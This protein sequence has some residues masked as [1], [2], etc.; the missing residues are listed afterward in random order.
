MLSNKPDHIAIWTE[1]GLATKQV[2]EILFTPVDS[3]K[4][5]IAVQSDSHLTYLVLRWNH[6]W[7]DEIRVLGDH[8]ERGYG[9]LEW[10]GI[11]PERCIPWYAL[12]HHV[13][14]R[15][16]EGFG[17]ETG[18]N[19][20]ASWRIDNSGISLVLD[21]RNG[22]MGVQ[23]GN[24]SLHAATLLSISSHDN[25]SA[26]A[27]AHRF[28]RSLCQ[29]PRLSKHPVYGGNDWYYRYGNNSASTV[30]E[31]ATLIRDLSPDTLNNPAFVVDAGWSPTGSCNGAPYDRG[32][33]GFPDMSGLATWMRHHS[34]RPGIWIRPLL[35]T[36]K[37]PT[38]WRVSKHHPF[39]TQESSY[40]DPSVPEVINLVQT[41][42]HRLAGWGY[43]VIKH[44]FTT[45]DIL[46]RWGFQMLPEVTSGGWSFADRTKTSAEIIRHLY[47]AIREAATDATIIGCNTIGHLTA[48]LFELQRSGDD[49]SGKIWERTR[50]MGINTLAMRLPQHQAFF[51]IDADCVGVTRDVSWTKT[52]QWLDVVARSGT[53][54][55]VSPDPA[56]VGTAQTVA[57]KA[58]FA[59]AARPHVTSEPIDWLDTT[60]PQRWRQAESGDVV[61]YNWDEFI[62]SSGLIPE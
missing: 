16:S 42:I 26:F 3:G 37:V 59:Y 12:I 55:F 43:E 52:K 11:V 21:L 15:R 31:D 46:G 36:E 20:F 44:D 14:S 8:W 58:A 62:G 57:L 28:C 24:R 27:F 2:A 10:R 38:S 7:N 41:D 9:D 49:T 19:C 39:G 29:S 54:L 22:G 13:K 40:L 5:G 33:T 53:P 56:A 6:A 32:S 45:Y 23:L 4:I 35:T 47:V 50:K 48:G 60:S 1:E 51:S 34:V 61:L 17:V 30:R 25:E 18:A